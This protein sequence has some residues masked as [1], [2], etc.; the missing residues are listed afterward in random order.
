MTHPLILHGRWLSPSSWKQRSTLAAAICASAVATG[1]CSS[2]PDVS[3]ERVAR[4]ETIV[5]QAEQTVGLSES[6]SVELQRAKA[7]L[8]MAKKAL[9]EQRA[10]EAERA[11]LQAELHAD[12]AIAQTEGAAAREAAAEMRA[13]IETLRKEAERNSPT[14][15]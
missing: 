15:R 14:L 2:V 5:Q 7:R 8:E 4:S 9:S 6:G 1:A 3:R 11:G 12:L 13:S 10:I